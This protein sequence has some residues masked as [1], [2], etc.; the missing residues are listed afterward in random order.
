ML[1]YLV[2]GWAEYPSGTP[3]GQEQMRALNDGLLAQRTLYAAYREYGYLVVAEIVRLN[4]Y[5]RY[6]AQAEPTGGR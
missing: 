1:H 5:F 6:H 4:E 3:T 2:T